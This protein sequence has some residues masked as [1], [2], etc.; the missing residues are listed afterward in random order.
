[1]EF[2]KYQLLRKIAKGGMAQLYLAIQRGPHGFEKVLV[3][4]CVLP[5]LCQGQEFVQMFLDEARLAA[6]LDHDNI[7]RVYDFGE[8]K[9]QY[10]LAMEYLP[11]EDLASMLQTCRRGGRQLPLELVADIV[12]GAA[13]GLHFAHGLSDARGR[14]LNIVH[15]DVSPSNIIVTYHGTVKLVDFGIARAET[16]V[17]KTAAGT[18]K[19]KFMYLS[20]EQAAG[21]AV[22]RRSDVF[23]LGTVVYELLTGVRIFK[24]DSDLATMEAVLRA[25]IMPP[26]EHRLDLPKELDRIVMKALSRDLGTRYQSAAELA[27]DLSRFLVD[28]GYVRS[29]E[30]LADFLTE[31]F[32]EERRAG[33][34]QVAQATLPDPDASIQRTP[35]LLRDLPSGLS[36]IRSESEVS[37][38][39]VP[40]TPEGASLAT[41]LRGAR[42]RWV[43][44][45]AGALGLALIVG[46]TARVV[47]GKHHPAE[48]SKPEERQL[49]IAPPAPAPPATPTPAPPAAE[50][51]VPPPTPAAAHK[52]AKGKLNLDTSPWT[53]VFLNGKS[54]GETPLL[55]VLLPAGRHTLK[56]V[57]DGKGIHTAIEIEIEPGK[58]TA[59]R[60]HF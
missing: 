50:S 13:R 12:I 54:L 45:A 58:T 29:E 46:L 55:N 6:H 56:L 38:V 43:L 41:M 2:G 35:S 34:L 24:R 17:I 59:K 40:T 11:G 28:R 49:P 30:A 19:G 33:K 21:D 7:V 44:S 42:R 5:E 60:L 48:S 51:A 52:V 15:R 32:G 4:K 14:P 26:S 18:L 25:P 53:E 57:N 8:V 47:T 1:M 22:D 16:N 10:F 27:E 36:P 31:L 23:A 3:L 9:G 37:I 20:P 39:P